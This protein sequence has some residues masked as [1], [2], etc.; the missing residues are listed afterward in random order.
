MEKIEGVAVA[1]P[2]VWQTTYLIVCI[3]F[4]GD[5]VAANCDQ[6]KHWMDFGVFLPPIPN[7]PKQKKIPEAAD[8]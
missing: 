8:K 3:C 2:K 5:T 1:Q 4:R 6:R 7:F